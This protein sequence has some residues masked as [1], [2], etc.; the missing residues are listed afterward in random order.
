MSEE[1]NNLEKVPPQS[2]SLRPQINY[3]ESLNP[4]GGLY[5]SNYGKQ[6]KLALLRE[7]RRIIFRHKWLILSIVLIVLPFVTI[8]AYRAK[9][10]YQATTTIEVRQEE[11]SLTRPSDAYYYD[12]DNTKSEIFIIKSQPV[13][14]RAVVNLKLD[15]NSRFLDVTTKRSVWEALTALKGGQT[16]QEKRIQ[17]LGR[18]TQELDGGKAKGG[19][20]LA[21]PEE[22]LPNPQTERIRLAPYA[23][24]LADNL[25][26]EGMRDTRLVKISFTHTDPEIAAIVAN[27]VASSF[28]THNFQTKTERFTTTSD[29]LEESTRKLKAQVEQAEQ[30]LANYSRENNIFSLEG[31]EN[32]TADKMVRL[33]DQVMR[34][35][36]DRLL[37]Q[38]LYEEVKQGRVA[39]LPEAFADPKTA[40]LRKAL[41]ELA[42]A[43]SQLSVKFGAKHPKLQEIKQQM[44]TIQEQIDLNKSMLEEKLRAD[45]ERAVREEGSLKVALNSAKGDA[46]QQNQATIQYSLLQQDLAT[47]KSLYTDFLNKTSQ[48]NIQ[49]AEQYNNVRLIEAAEPPGGPIGPNRSRMILLGFLV[50]LALGVG[51]AYLLENL[52]TAIRNVE[53]LSRST[54][55]PALA[56]IPTLTSGAYP[57]KR[58]GRHELR[59]AGMKDIGDS[60]EQIVDY[61]SKPILADSLKKFSAAAEAYRML[62]TSLLLSTAGH[63]PRTMLVTSGQPGDGKTTT[64]FNAAIAFTQLGARVVIV[65]CDM[66]K[67]RIHKMVQSKKKRGLS[68]FLSGGGE[69]DDFI[70]PTPVPNLSVLQ[71]GHVPPNPSELISSDKMRELLGLLTERFDYVILDSP[72]LA[73]VTDPM[74]LSTLVDGVILVVKSGKSKSELVRRACQDLNG[75]GAKILGVVLND[76]D[77]R[78]EGY[79]YYNYYR[80]YSDYT[81]HTK[82]NGATG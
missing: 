60:I 53:D 70:H 2:A 22:I 32:L 8:Q 54:Q 43:A 51:L 28:I 50:S 38:S 34:A 4:E 26:V 17:E 59:A 19:E 75:V 63:P 77:I 47:A 49:R 57:G 1:R 16:D 80:Y 65:D 82:S 20:N 45:F 5:G 24:A 25:K 40:E 81:D 71:C 31:K 29:W 30:R 67:P 33:H 15:R 9:S 11:S 6:A 41:N 64:A 62:R 12:S 27:G 3:L 23:Q 66:R 73:T 46:V 79:D 44:V 10:L 14:K 18:K 39:Q 58:N 76:L 21:D 13:I 78:R 35:E 74:I 36:T 42:V 72:P 52:N 37:K 56:V 55:L 68:T 7:W 69:L 48:A 61:S